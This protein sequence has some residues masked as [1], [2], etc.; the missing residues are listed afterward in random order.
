MSS[1]NLPA[2]YRSRALLIV[3]GEH[4]KDVLFRTLLKCFPELSIQNQN[5]WFYSTNIY[6][7]YQDIEQEYGTDWDIQDVDLPFLIAQKQNLTDKP[8]MLDFT[9]IILVFDYERQDPCFSEEKIC[10][11][12][13]YFSD[14]TNMGKLYLNYPMVESYLH[15]KSI[16]D[17]CF[18]TL[19]FPASLQRGSEYKKL[20]HDTIVSKAMKFPD[21]LDRLLKNVLG[22]VDDVERYKDREML[23]A[24]NS[25]ETIRHTIDIIIASVSDKDRAKTGEYCLPLLIGQC[26][27]VTERLS[28]WQYMRKMFIEIIMHNISKASHIADGNY[29][30]QKDEFEIFFRNMRLDRILALQNDASRDVQNGY[31]WVLNT[32][33][34]VV[35]DY[36]FSLIQA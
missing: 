10:R 28:Y 24:C 26:Q 5:V 29:E 11:L 3:E 18:K 23:L 34:F 9:N 15:F 1:I 4:E 32:C 14:P 36:R 7:L 17:P 20:L 12:Q 31:I 8:R 16:P 13:S 25:M 6:M 22:I 19:R 2:R 33:V 27:Y 30:L 35:A 21:K